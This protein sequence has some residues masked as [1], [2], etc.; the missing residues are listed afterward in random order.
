[1]CP[2][3]RSMSSA[4]AHGLAP[5]TSSFPVS[6]VALPSLSP[7]TQAEVSG[8]YTPDDPSIL[9][10][11]YTWLST[12]G[13]IADNKGKPYTVPGGSVQTCP[14]STASSSSTVI[15]TTAKTPTST[16]APSTT[17]TSATPTH[18]GSSAPLYGQCGGSG[19][20][21]ATWCT[22]GSCVA[23]NNYYSQCLP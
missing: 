20:T 23:S 17:A 21:G 18:T 12:G 3:H 15:A 10:D 16:I 9:I 7:R 5:T 1:M 2:V 6:A 22:S 4:Q 14:G 8:A 11:I 19:W 13:G